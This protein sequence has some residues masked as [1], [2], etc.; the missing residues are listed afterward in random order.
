[1]TLESGDVFTAHI[2]GNVLVLQ[3]FGTTTGNEVASACIVPTDVALLLGY[4]DA[5]TTYL[6]SV[7]ILHCEYDHYRL[8][9]DDHPVMF[10][11]CEWKL[12]IEAVKSQAW[13]FLQ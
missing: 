1:M 9:F 11:R 8:V 3:A 7:D 2:D 13:R 12:F 5:D 4:K 10:N 6:S